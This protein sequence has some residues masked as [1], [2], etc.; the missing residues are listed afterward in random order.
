MP[1]IQADVLNSCLF[2]LLY[3]LYNTQGLWV[4]QFPN[5]AQRNTPATSTA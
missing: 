5:W 3:Q 2:D 4:Q 1:G